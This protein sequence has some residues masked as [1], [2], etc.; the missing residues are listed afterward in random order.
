M[1]L[2]NFAEEC[3]LS[4]LTIRESFL[5]VIL[6][7]EEEVP[8]S[9]LFKTVGFSEELFG[10]SLKDKSTLPDNI[11]FNNASCSDL[12]VFN[13]LHKRV[14]IT[15]LLKE[16][17]EELF[18]D[19]LSVAI[20]D[21]LFLLELLADVFS[22]ALVEAFIARDCCFFGTPLVQVD[23][24]FLDDPHPAYV[25][26]CLYRIFVVEQGGLSSTYVNKNKS[27]KKRLPI[28]NFCL[29]KLINFFFLK[30]SWQSFLTRTI[31]QK[32]LLDDRSWEEHL[33]RKKFIAWQSFLIKQLLDQ[34]QSSRKNV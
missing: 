26:L 15:L 11:L 4:T 10:R 17:F 25:V 29:F 20:L 27:R 2:S 24:V 1:L 5:D 14:Q 7:W 9:S 30:P 18:V 23:V 33:R 8:V 13:K 16:V 19:G 12:V 21:L 6:S 32:K 31:V 34:E 3:L 22:Y 28:S